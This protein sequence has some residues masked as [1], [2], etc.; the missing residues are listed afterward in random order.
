[1]SSLAAWRAAGAP[2][3]APCVYCCGGV[4]ESKG[5]DGE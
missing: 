4:E 1:M 2:V 3:R 5:F